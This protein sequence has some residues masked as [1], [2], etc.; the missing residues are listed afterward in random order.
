VKANSQPPIFTLTFMPRNDAKTNEN[1]FT[2]ALCLTPHSYFHPNQKGVTFLLKIRGVTLVALLGMLLTAIIWGFNVSAYTYPY[3]DPSLSVEERVTDL[4]A[5]MTLA[6]K[7]GQMIQTECDLATAAEVTKYYLGS[8]FN[9]GGNVPGPNTPTGWCDMIDNFQKAALAT[10]LQIPFIYGTDAVHGHNNVGGATVFPHN[11]GLGAAR[12]VDLAERIGRVV[13]SEVRA[14]GA[15][16]NF[17]PCITVPQNEKW[18]RT[19]EGFSEDTDLVAKLGAAFVKGVQGAD[20]P[21]GLTEKNHIAAC[22]KHWIGDGATEGGVNAGNAII[23]DAVLRLKYLP[24]YLAGIAA[25]ARTVMVSY[26]QVNGVP[27]H[28]HEALLTTLLKGELGF[29]GFVVSDYDG[30]DAND[31]SDYKNAVKIAVN[32][33]IDMI[34]VA[35]KWKTCLAAIIA[36]TQ[37][38][39]IARSRIDDAVRRI[40]RV[41][42]Q[43]GLFENPYSDRTLMADFGSGEHRAVAREAVRKSLVLLKNRD[44]LLPLAK[45]GQRILVAGKCAD[46]IGYQCGGWTITWQ[47]VSGNI[48]GGTSI[49]QGIRNVA[50]GNTV[51]FQQDGSGASAYDVAIVVIGETPYAEADGDHQTLALDSTDLQTLANVKNSG[52]PTVAVLVSGRPLIVT[53]YLTNWDALVAA[54]LPGTEGQGVAEVLFGDYD[55][56]GK[57]PYVWPRSVSQLPLSPNDGQKPLFA[58]G[59]GLTY[60]RTTPPELTPVV[61]P[62]VTPTPVVSMGKKFTIAYVVD[63]D[64]GSGATV[65]VTIRNNSASAVNNWYLLWSFAGDQK[66]ANLWDGIVNQSGRSVQV[67]NACYNGEIAA[68]GGKVSFG[69]NLYY[70]GANTKPFKFALNGVTCQVQ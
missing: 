50:T 4:L 6:E 12:D 67:T 60:G 38:G 18:S 45:T 16:W 15:H 17:A 51:A 47:G 53:D 14:T 23:T 1:E 33:G 68:G 9:G 57:L 35:K 61:T 42:L 64:W 58:L 55:F 43:L 37:S 48:A 54:W 10:R 28:S 26:N 62:T 40:L 34:V 59:A 31:L 39:D 11:I 13:A 69:F 56:S 5:R 3:Q 20:Y 63:N 44:N 29:D 21:R 66:I 7:A 2:H 30:I 65:T 36:L 49:L 24:P 41:K 27:C 46:N 52:V 25:G 22:L 8:I 19:Y 70:S 32:A